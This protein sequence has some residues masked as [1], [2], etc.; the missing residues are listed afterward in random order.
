MS[1]EQPKKSQPINQTR[2]SVGLEDIDFVADSKASIF[3]RSSPVANLILYLMLAFVLTLFVWSYFSEIDEVTKAEG[4]V[5]PPSEIKTIQSLEGG[6]VKDIYVVEGQIVKKD[7]P[8]IQLDATQF[9]S[10]YQSDLRRYNSLQATVGRLAAQ[11]NLSKQL[12]YSDDFMKEH[13]ELVER[14]KRLFEANMEAFH[15]S[16]RILEENYALAKREL[17]LIEPLVQEKYA[18]EVDLLHIRR[19]VNKIETDIQNRRDLYRTQ[20]L[21]DYNTN[22]A[23]LESLSERLKALRD[24][25]QRTVLRSPVDGIINNMQVTTVGG[26]VR[27]GMDVMQVVPREEGLLV[28]ARVKPSDIAFLHIN[29]KAT[30]KFTAYDYSIYGGLPAVVTAISADTLTDKEGKSYYEIKLSTDKN[31]LGT[32]QNALPIIPG[33]TVTADIL[34]GR[35]TILSYILKPILR[36][37]SNALTER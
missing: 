16:I 5:I 21:T 13:P 1:D 26:V 34:T 14:E 29:Q 11:A 23:E 20:S 36:A 17:E 32:E 15:E 31:Y 19:D 35:K 24:R 28:E 33:M 22:Q 30:I 6:I 10:E 18:S 37:K 27:P 25:M 3:F 8:L 7:E 12:T 4:K 2:D 9:S